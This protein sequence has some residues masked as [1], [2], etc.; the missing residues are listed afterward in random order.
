VSAVVLVG[1]VFALAHRDAFATLLAQERLIFAFTAGLFA[2][3]AGRRMFAGSAAFGVGAAASAALPAW[4]FEINGLA[5]LA[6][7]SCASL[8][9]WPARRD[10]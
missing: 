10:G 8:V 3:L 6:A 1:R 7:M 2:L 9:C 5:A 4:A